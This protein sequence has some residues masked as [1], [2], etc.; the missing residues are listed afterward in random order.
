[1]MNDSPSSLKTSIMH[2][3]EDHGC[4]AGAPIKESTHHF[5]GVQYTQYTQQADEAGDDLADP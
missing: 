3:H 2:Y 1:M 4:S 5:L